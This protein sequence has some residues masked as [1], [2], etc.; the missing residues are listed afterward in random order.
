[1]APNYNWNS[2]YQKPNIFSYLNIKYGPEV[3][4][5]NLKS[6]KIVCYMPES[7]VRIDLK[8]VIWTILPFLWIWLLILWI[9]KRHFGISMPIKRF[10]AHSEVSLSLNQYRGFLTFDILFLP[11]QT[12]IITS[13]HWRICNYQK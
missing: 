9:Y 11:K 3:W 6:K 2:N 4:I 13:E 12:T 8:K 1:M 10:C 7:N 5:H